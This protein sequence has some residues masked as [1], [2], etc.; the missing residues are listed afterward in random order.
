MC[1]CLIVIKFSPRR[2]LRRIKGVETIGMTCYT[3]TYVC[4]GTNWL[5]AL[6]QL[7][8]VAP[9]HYADDGT[10]VVRYLKGVLQT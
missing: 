2:C 4:V 5:C 10:I 7:T 8:S 3:D 1:N 9:A 6:A